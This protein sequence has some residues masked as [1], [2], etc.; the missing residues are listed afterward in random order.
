M[1]AMEMMVTASHKLVR[2]ARLTPPGCTHT[3]S[4]DKSRA[5]GRREAAGLGRTTRRQTGNSGDGDNT[6]ANTSRIEKNTKRCA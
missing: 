2:E 3:D 1:F 5:A 4:S 6:T